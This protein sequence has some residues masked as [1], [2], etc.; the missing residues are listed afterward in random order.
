MDRKS[1]L[2]HYIETGGFIAIKE[3]TYKVDWLELNLT[4]FFILVGYNELGI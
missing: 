4:G 2:L 1:A 3:E